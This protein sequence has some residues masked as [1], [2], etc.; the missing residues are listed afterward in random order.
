MRA[1]TMTRGA[2]ALGLACVLLAGCSK[3]AVE[4]P[5]AS[6]PADAAAAAK[7]DREPDEAGIDPTLA[8][9]NVAH[10][11]VAET[12]VTVPTP[13]DNLDSPASWITPDGQRWVIATA[14]KSSEL[15]V[16]DGDTGQRLRTVAGKGS[17]PG[18]LDRPNGI[19]VVGD[20]VLV[21]ER[22]NHRVQAF[23][24][25][26]F[27]SVAVF[28]ADDLK[29]P[30]GLWAHEKDG[31]IEVIV[32]DNYMQGADEKTVPPL[33]DLGQRFRRYELKQAGGRWKATLTQTFGDT[34]EAGAIRIAES[35]FG[36]ADNNRLMLAEED[37]AVGT[38][39]REYRMD[40]SY[41]GR[42]VGADLYKAQA[43]GIALLAC[44]DGSGYWIGTDQFKDRSV[45]QVFDRRTLQPVG[46]FAGK[47]TANTDG[48]WMDAHGDARFPQ[49]VFYALHDDQAVA[50]FD[51]RDIASALKL[52]ECKR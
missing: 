22:D 49:G 19:S 2:A 37:M 31:G 12:F 35:V 44:A 52:P 32:S 27:K 17:A 29:K 8:T 34:T 25:P 46:A 43:E 50:A 21:V 18:Q 42:D 45:F 3:P 40:G 11:V 9:S 26:D 33:A 36:D 47:V 6:A 38:R 7:A 16:F 51:W 20:L 28:G 24:L 4:A 5:A 1:A 30:Y 48:V 13:E 15:V 10:V 41:T 14:K 23:S 39:L